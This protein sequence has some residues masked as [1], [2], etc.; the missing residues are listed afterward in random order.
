MDAQERNNEDGSHVSEIVDKGMESYDQ[1]SNAEWRDEIRSF[2][3]L[4]PG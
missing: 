3:T 1:A 2:P 4:D